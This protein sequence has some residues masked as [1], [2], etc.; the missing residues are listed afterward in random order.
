MEFLA[1]IKK[2]GEGKEIIP[3]ELEPLINCS[4]FDIKG[5]DLEMLLDALEFAL[6]KVSVSDF[7]GLYEHDFGKTEMGIIDGKPFSHDL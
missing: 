3:K 2:E 7:R 6:S 1:T 5:M 4:L